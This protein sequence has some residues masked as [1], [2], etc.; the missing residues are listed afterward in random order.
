[1]PL[2]TGSFADLIVLDKDPFKVSAQ[3]LFK[4]KPVLTM[5]SGEI[6]FSR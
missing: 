6:V 2:S 3:E 4:L 1:M 5:V